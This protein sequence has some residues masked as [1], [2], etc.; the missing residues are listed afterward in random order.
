MHFPGPKSGTRGS[1]LP[2]FARAEFFR[3]MIDGVGIDGV[4]INVV[5]INDAGADGVG[6]LVVVS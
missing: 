4:G 5:G 2:A 6:L 3:S 1:R